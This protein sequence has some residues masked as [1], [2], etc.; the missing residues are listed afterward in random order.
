[1]KAKTTRGILLI[2][3]LLVSV[4]ACGKK[5]QEAVEK[6]QAARRDVTTLQAD[7]VYTHGR[8]YT[9]SEK[10]PWAE[11]V[12]I[13]GGKFIKVGSNADIE[14]V[15]GPDTKVVDLGGKF[16]MPGMHD[17]HIHTLDVEVEH[18]AGNFH[19]DSGM[20]KDEM[21]R[22]L[23]TYADAHPDRE[24]IVGADYPM[25]MFPK[26][27]AP[28]ELLDEII[29]DRPVAVLHQS[30]HALWVNSKALEMAGIT[31]DTP[32]PELGFI[33]RDPKTGE[34]SGTLKES[35]MP[36]VMKYYFKY[37][38]EQYTKAVKPTAELFNRN[39]ITSVRSATGRTE[40]LQALREM[41]RRGELSLRFLMSWNWSTT[42]IEPVA[43]LDVIERRVRENLVHVT[44]H[45]RA[46]SLKIFV[47]G[48]FDSYSCAMLEPYEGKPDNY[49]FMNI[50]QEDFDNVI[51][52]F[53]AIGVSVIM[54]CIG[55]GASRAA[56]N[57]I[58]AARKTNGPG[59]RHQ[60]SHSTLITQEDLQRVK[61][62]QASMDFSPIMP[63]TEKIV[64]SAAAPYIGMKRSERV[65]PMRWAIDAGARP[66]L[67][68]DHA[69][70]PVIPF[71]DIETLVTRRDP[72]TNKGRPIGENLKCTVEEAIE[73]Y[74]LNG[75]YTMMQENEVGS[76]EVGKY[77][78][79]IVLSQNLLEIPPEQI[80][81]TQVLQTLFEGV[82]V[83]DADMAADQDQTTNM[84]TLPDGLMVAL[85]GPCAK[86]GWRH[87]AHEKSGGCP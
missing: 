32:D 20:G 34:P 39:G 61:Q 3:L 36:L 9:V 26:E 81:E 29:P 27:N 41:D 17:V 21:L 7:V 87:D 22:A 77:A 66:A 1:M 11:A 47:D 69:V 45:V 71:A 70:S 55:D 38:P 15:V 12:A 63:L 42:L 79:F 53:D 67:A 76:I 33:I 28:K 2:G 23:K 52:K 24:W 43:P 14:D 86:C 49:G 8:I 58:E 37:T 57:A 56:L 84:R 16:V 44:P 85:L 78:D 82:V 10:R 73:A 75:A 5:D 13:R 46:N 18:V 60:V 64:E 50:S 59:M 83:Y 31:K 74:T 6:Q 35:A 72:F 80:S 25:G 4:V 54:H 68:S 40:H 62:L 51:T 30:G 65:F 19:R 48:T